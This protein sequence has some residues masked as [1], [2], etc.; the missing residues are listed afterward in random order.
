VVIGAQWGDEGKGKITNLLAQEADV[1]VRYQGGRRHPDR[2]W[3]GVRAAGRYPALR[4]IRLRTQ[5]T[6]LVVVSPSTP[7][8]AVP[9]NTMVTMT[10]RRL[11]SSR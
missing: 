1:V 8:A 4:G 10:N 3:H 2:V 11:S 7:V 6:A 5:R 9:W